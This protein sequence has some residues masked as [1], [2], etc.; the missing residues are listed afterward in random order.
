LDQ[1]STSAQNAGPLNYATSSWFEDVQYVKFANIDINQGDVI[2]YSVTGNSTID[3]GYADSVMAAYLNGAQIEKTDSEQ[4]DVPKFDNA[5]TGNAESGGP[6]NFPHTVNLVYNHSAPIGVHLMYTVDGTDPNDT[7]GGSTLEFTGTPISITVSPTTIKAKSFKSGYRTS[8]I[9]TEVYTKLGLLAP[10]ITPTSGQYPYPLSLT[11]T[12]IE[13]GTAIFYTTDGT[14]PNTSAGGSTIAYAGPFN[15]TVNPTT[16]KTLSTKTGFAAS[17]VTTETYTRAVVPPVVQD[18]T[19]CLDNTPVVGLVLKD[20]LAG[21]NIFYT[22][23]GTTPATSVTGSTQQYTT[24]INLTGVTK[25][26]AIATKTGYTNSIT[27]EADYAP[28]GLPTPDIFRADAQTGMPVNGITISCSGHSGATIYYTIDGTDPR[29]I[30]SPLVYT[31][32]FNINQATALTVKAFAR[33]SGYSDSCVASQLFDLTGVAK[34][35]I[36]PTPFNNYAPLTATLTCATGGASIYYTVNGTDPKNTNNPA[37]LGP[38]SSPKTV[39]ITEATTITAYASKANLGDSD[40]TITSYG[41][42]LN[43]ISLFYEGRN[44]DKVGSRNVWGP[45]DSIPPSGDPKDWELTAIINLSAVSTVVQ[46]MRLYSSDAAGNFLYSQRASTMLEPDNVSPAWYPLM[47]FKD[48]IQLNNSSTEPLGT[49]FGMTR[50]KLYMQPHIDPQ[51]YLTLYVKLGDGSVITKTIQEIITTP[52]PNP[53]LVV[54]MDFFSRTLGP[55][56]AVGDSPMVGPAA[57]G[58]ST[59]DYWNGLV[60]E[61]NFSKSPLKNFDASD[62]PVSIALT[63]GSVLGASRNGTF[64][65]MNNRMYDSYIYGLDPLSFT[66]T[67]LPT[68]NYTIVVYGHGF[69]NIENGKFQVG[70]S[71]TSLATDNSWKTLPQIPNSAP[72]VFYW[73][74]PQND[75][76]YNVVPVIKGTPVVIN[77]LPGTSGFSIISGIQIQLLT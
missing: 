46:G 73:G 25:L 40:I 69:D 11:I 53:Q 28:I 32:P 56:V 59:S 67:G 13:T 1:K 70:N 20:T 61:N 33:E 9:R 49:F 10:V 77:V 7:V 17:P 2:S 54:N 35:S 21:A 8:P 45:G 31:A 48:N 55:S 19:P 72:P 16:I 18:P 37:R 47:V 52:P 34:V 6:V 15:V 71:V 23:D 5:A 22:T 39:T 51:Q 50:F 63:S 44:T 3:V 74:Y 75:A 24:P 66:I 57:R 65:T 68:G 62:S 43:S 27:T 26:K 29:Y 76:L 38:F 14:T 64:A 36:T 4:L 58:I 60:S 30:A 42:A 41:P 12:T